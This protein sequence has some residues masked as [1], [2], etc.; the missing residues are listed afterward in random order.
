MNKVYVLI[1]FIFFLKNSIAYELT[2]S[3]NNEREKTFSIYYNGSA[4]KIKIK[5]LNTNDIFIATL[6]DKKTSWTPQTNGV[7]KFEVDEDF[8]IYFGMMNIKFKS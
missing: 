3:R 1:L 5:N 7:Y 4:D 8:K 6:N 2:I